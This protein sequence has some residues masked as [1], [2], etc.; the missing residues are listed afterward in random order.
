MFTRHMWLMLTTEVF[1][2]IQPY[3][4]SLQEAMRCWTITSIDNTLASVT[5]EVYNSGLHDHTGITSGHMGPKSRAFVDRCSLFF[6]DTEASN[7]GKAQW[8]ML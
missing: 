7:K 3:P 1:K 8:S 5:F 4:N 6:P 2:G